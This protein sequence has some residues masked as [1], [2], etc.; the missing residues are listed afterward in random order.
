MSVRRYVIKVTC[1]G[2]TW[3][4]HRNGERI[5]NKDSALKVTLADAW[6]ICKNYQLYWKAQTEIVECYP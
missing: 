1:E 3:Y 2:E 5:N 4:V 6:D